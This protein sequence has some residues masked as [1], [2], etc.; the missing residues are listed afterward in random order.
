[1][2]DFNEKENA[3]SDDT[4]LD[5]AGGATEAPG[6][7]ET[8]KLGELE[9]DGK[10]SEKSESEGVGEEEKRDIATEAPE[11]SEEKTEAET[12]ITTAGAIETGNVASEAC[13]N[14]VE[15]Y[16]V[17]GACVA[18]GKVE[19]KNEI[20]LRKLWL[21][22]SAALIL[23]IVAFTGAF[24]GVVYVCRTSIFGDSEFFAAFVAKWSGV[25]ENR[26]EVDC[27]SG[28]YIDD[29]AELAD[30]VLANSVI[31]RNGYRNATGTFVQTASGSGVIYSRNGN[32]YYI[33][34]NYH[35]VEGA[36][37]ILTEIYSPSSDTPKRFEA[38]ACALDKSGDIAVL[39]FECDE[40]LAV[41]TQGDSSKIK[42][43][44]HIIVAGNPLGS[45]FA[46]SLGYISNPY[47]EPTSNS[48]VPLTTVDVSVN[49]GN[50]GGGVYDFAGN[51]IGI[52]V[53]KASG[54][55]IDGIGYAIPINEVN[56]IIDDLFTFGYVKGRATI[57]ITCASLLNISHYRS[58]V[59]GELNGYIFDTD[60]PHYGIYIF[61]SS[62]PLLL[63]GDRIVS[64]N[65]E[66]IS[67]MQ[68]ISEI[69]IGKK[70]GNVVSITVERAT[71]TGDEI[72]YTTVTLDILLV[73][74][75][76]K[77]TLG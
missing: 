57:G 64:I 47:K 74:R 76:E 62:N 2:N 55:D 26:V 14:G 49:P 23:L 61:E 71:K 53:A 70:P 60:E 77:D 36:K 5:G 66:G 59:Q 40:E 3:L 39:K 73:E 20:K 7:G 22:I 54:D 48:C 24:F 10:M 42:A 67:V 18:T 29:T 16:T 28:E 65:G 43:G 9:T 11:I 51:L 63:K 72:T 41:A 17:T 33:V 68:D 52:V 50:S 21:C 34:T 69:L 8:R 1:M 38:E 6:N 32:V 19:N 4:E 44:Q 30:K 31:V 12:E 37:C 75:T 45:G 46:V 15:G 58:A 25:I 13:E 35:V 56:D 27:I